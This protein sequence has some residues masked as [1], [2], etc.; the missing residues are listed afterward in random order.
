VR[1]SDCGDYRIGLGVYAL[2]RLADGA[3]S[4]ALRA[5]VAAC[6]PCRRELDELREVAGLLEQARPA[7]WTRRG[8]GRHART[9][10]AGAP[11][12]PLN[13]ACAAS[14]PRGR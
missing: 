12:T 8:A 11:G 9:R 1:A 7:L 3:E 4:A 14:R 6:L 10:T 13:G 2:G 5:H